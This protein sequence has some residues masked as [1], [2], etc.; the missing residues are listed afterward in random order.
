MYGA[1]QRDKHGRARLMLLLHKTCNE[2]VAG[3]LLSNGTPRAYAASPHC[4][5][6]ETLV[7]LAKGNDD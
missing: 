4:D 7:T 5:R 3:Q 2:A 6:S 1:R